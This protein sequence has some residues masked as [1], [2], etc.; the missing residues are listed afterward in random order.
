MV[1][2][3]RSD[4]ANSRLVRDYS[5]LHSLLSDMDVLDQVEFDWGRAVVNR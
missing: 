4:S 2:D 1:A 5:G 3:V